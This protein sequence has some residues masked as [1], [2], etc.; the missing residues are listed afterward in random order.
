[1][2]THFTI[3]RQVSAGHS[4]SGHPRCKHQHGHEWT[5][6]ITIKGIPDV[7]A[8][9]N[10]AKHFDAFAS[11]IDGKSLNDLNPAG[12]PT[13]YGLALWA[14]ERLAMVIPNLAGIEVSIPNEQ[15]RVSA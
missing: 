11:E 5:I 12:S 14:W 2:N 9:V 7:D 15:S 6:S 1:M 8:Q 10:M 13:T 4:I 3:D